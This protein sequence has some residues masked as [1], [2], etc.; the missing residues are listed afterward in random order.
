MDASQHGKG[1]QV[2]GK[3]LQNQELQDEKWT[4]QRNPLESTISNDTT[5]EGQLFSM[6]AIDP[7]L[8]AKMAIL[9]QVSIGQFIRIDKLC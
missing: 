9:N 8:D 7:A 2:T 4:S 1:V 3:P 6:S 5:K